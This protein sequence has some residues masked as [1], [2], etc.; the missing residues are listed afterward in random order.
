LAYTTHLYSNV[1]LTLYSIFFISLIIEPF[2]EIYYVWAAAIVV[3]IIGYIIKL[4]VQEIEKNNE[5]ILRMINNS[6]FERV[7]RKQIDERFRLLPKKRWKILI[8]F[9]I[10]VGIYFSIFL[11]FNVD[12]PFYV[13]SSASMTPVLNVGDLLIVKDGNTFNSLKVGDIIVFNRPQ[14]G[15]RV[16]VHRIIEISDRLGE[17]VIVTKGDANDG[18]IPGTD[19]PIREKD[20]IGKVAYI[21]PKGGLVL[22]PLVYYIIPFIFF[23]F[24]FMKAWYLMKKRGDKN[25]FIQQK[26]NLTVPSPLKGFTNYINTKY[27]LVIQ[28]PKYWKKNDL[29]RE[30]DNLIALVKFHDIKEKSVLMIIFIHKEKSENF[31]EFLSLKITE[32]KE[33]YTILLTNSDFSDKEMNTYGKYQVIYK[34]DESAEIKEYHQ[35][36]VRYMY[37]RNRIYEFFCQSEISSF[38]TN[39]PLFEKIIDTIQIY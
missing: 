1:Y 22:T 24:P 4:I 3:F 35:Y 10:L 26:T 28:Y 18:I 2:S 31:N 17:K 8:Y 16:I 33:Q 34:D 19:F 7:L 21:V 11:I 30:S 6:P 29:D 9:A 5:K 13:V 32:L 20:Y 25:S 39:L 14:G 12:N 36:L 37:V 38:D 27:S 15:D 23:I